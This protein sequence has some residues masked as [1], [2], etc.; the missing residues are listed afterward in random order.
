MEQTLVETKT[1]NNARL[2]YP[3]IQSVV[4]EE[5][6][7]DIKWNC[8]IQYDRQQNAV[9]H[10]RIMSF[11]RRTTEIVHHINSRP[12]YPASESIWQFQP[13][14]QND[15]LLGKYNIPPQPE[16]EER[17]SEPQR[18]DQKYREMDKRFLMLLDEILRVKPTTKEQMV[19][20]R[21]AW[22]LVI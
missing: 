21:K 6:A 5:F 12:W 11:H 13:I 7:C 4:A 9:F 1:R 19:S 16:C 8:N 2:E 14:T 15:I 10:V 18:Y 17:A 20:L 3:Q 22:K